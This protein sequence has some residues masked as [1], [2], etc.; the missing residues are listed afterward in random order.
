M[1]I[2]L[3][4]AD[5]RILLGTHARHMPNLRALARAGAHG[6]IRSTR[7]PITVP[8][9]VTMT[10]GKDPG[11]LGIYGFH[12]RVP[13]TYDTRL[14]T[15][16]D[17]ACPRIWD[18]AAA[19][20]LRSVVVGV[21]LTWPPPQRFSGVMVTGPLT[22]SAR[23]EH[24]APASLAADLERRFGPFVP[25]VTGFRGE[26]RAG[27]V[28]RIIA[29]TAQRFDTAEHL[30]RT[31]RWDLLMVV[32]MGLDRFQ[33]AFLRHLVA[34]HPANRGNPDP[35]GEV[36]AI[37]YLRMLDDRVG[38]LAAL[39]GGDATVMVVSDHGVQPL[40]GGFAICDWLILN[41]YLVLQNDLPDEPARLTVGDIDWSRT[42][43]WAQ[44]GYVG[45]IDLNV[46]GREPSG[47]VDPADR[48]AIIEEMI[49]GLESFAL[50]D[51]TPMGNRAVRPVDQYRA[52]EGQPPDLVVELGDL[53]YRAVATV[54]HRS[55]VVTGNDTGPDDA[56]HD[57]F[58]M[59]VASGPGIEPGTDLGTVPI[60]DVLWERFDMEA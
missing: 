42:R 53:A 15:S 57:R 5:G 50:S 19:R 16:A 44:G 26:D 32:D 34:D 13:G 46:K 54:G 17:V 11:E 14:F 10:T 24:T 30:A 1:V 18:L 59:V 3:D 43:A 52:L 25:D 4:C 38:R 35:E 39:A 37:A 33:H 55:L 36:S 12:G 20:G 23:S 48:D 7:P 58:G 45:R 21:P 29:C 8:A 41:G 28:D 27:L 2:G 9:W 31:E 6:R 22:P 51:G 40:A 60:E 47:I 49:A 56:N